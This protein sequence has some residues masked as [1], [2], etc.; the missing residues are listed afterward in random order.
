MQAVVVNFNQTG[1][2]TTDSL[3][4]PNETYTFLCEVSGDRLLLAS[5]DRNGTAVDTFNVFPGI[6][7]GGAPDN[8]VDFSFTRINSAAGSAA[9]AVMSSST[10]RLSTTLEC[11]DVNDMTSASLSTDV[12]CKFGHLNYIWLQCL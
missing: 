10:S 9:I 7:V 3:L 2:R 12:K 6:P 5:S 11:I 8:Q 1:I 4:C